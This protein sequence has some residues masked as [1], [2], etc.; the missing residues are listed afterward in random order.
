MVTGRWLLARAQCG[1]LVDVNIGAIT[2]HLA[3]EA[4]GHQVKEVVDSLSDGG[5]KETPAAADEGNLSA[6]ILAQVQ[7][8]QSALKDDQELV[9]TCTVG[10]ATLRVHEL[11][12]PSSRMMVVTGMDTDRAITRVISPAA[13]LQLVCKP[14][15]VRPEMKPVRIRLVLPKPK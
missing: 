6:A 13:A 4:L 14:T 3:Q 8:M 10:A 1:T 7:A 9:V 15:A 2:K 5:A 12:A 11:F